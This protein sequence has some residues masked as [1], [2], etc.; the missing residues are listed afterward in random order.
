M[1][2]SAF[3]EKLKSS[4]S[5]VE[6]IDSYIPLKKKGKEHEACCPF[7]AE[8]N[9]SFKVNEEKE[10]FH[11]FGCGVSGNLIDFVMEYENIGFADA[12]D[13]IAS[14]FGY[15][16]ERGKGD[17]DKIGTIE[18][19]SKLVKFIDKI[20]KKKSATGASPY[21]LKQE[22]IENLGLGLAHNNKFLQ[23][24]IRDDPNLKK[25]SKNVNFHSGFLKFPSD[26]NALSIPVF[27][28]S[29]KFAGLYIVSQR[30]HYLIGSKGADNGLLYNPSGMIKKHHPIVI[31]TDII[32]A[33]RSHELGLINSL[34]V[35]DT[36]AK[37][38][39]NSMLKTYQSGQIYCIVKNTPE[40]TA[41]LCSSLVEAIKLSSH[42]INVRVLIINEKISLS[43]MLNSNGI[44]ILP[45]I[46]S[47][48]NLWSDFIAKE[49]T[50]GKDSHS[51]QFKL[52]MSSLL[53][54]TFETSNK[55]KYIGLLL[56]EVSKSLGKCS[57]LSPQSI[58]H[59]AEQSIDSYIKDHL[60]QQ[61]V[62]LREKHLEYS[63]RR[64]GPFG[65][66]EV[67]SF[68]AL[69]LL[70]QKT[71]NCQTFTPDVIDRMLIILNGDNSFKK[72][73]TLSDEMEFV[74]NKDV[75]SALGEIEFFQVNQC[76]QEMMQDDF[77]IEHAT[78]K[79]KSLFQ[80]NESTNYLAS[81]AP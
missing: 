72:T 54:S 56:D 22:T 4:V 31:N 33:I 47:K 21:K 35:A 36:V 6:L 39:T 20:F 29:K 28:T 5:I 46:L 69:F 2:T 59:L 78:S 70:H 11:C 53:L 49:L 45:T 34:G 17:K 64:V 61:E 74:R 1:I 23:D 27:K 15:T 80:Q 19:E 44:D 3:I 68:T 48:A 9:P 77:A 43:D 63:K 55:H 18:A 7:H 38:V 52:A 8:K 81:F 57:R 66:R 60:T 10:L 50:K 42:I 73:V 79:I 25:A 58:F 30:E 76:L 37:T 67:D 51:E 40:D 71:M 62:D 75:E 24:A 41:R 13:T 14:K 32:D 16:V 26:H 12:V 65:I